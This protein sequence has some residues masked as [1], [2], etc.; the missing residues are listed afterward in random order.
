MTKEKQMKKV[1]ALLEKIREK[2]KEVKK[3]KKDCEHQIQINI[4]DVT[5]CLFCRKK[6]ES[7]RLV[8][9]DKPEPVEI[10]MDGKYSDILRMWETPKEAFQ[11]LEACY[12]IASRK[13]KKEDEYSIGR[14]M[15]MELNKLQHKLEEQRVIEMMQELELQRK[16]DLI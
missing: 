13:Q 14:R 6:M 10:D 11:K 5:V 3:I 15:L 9:F 12:R 4:E 16:N 2:R 1:D 7:V 8:D